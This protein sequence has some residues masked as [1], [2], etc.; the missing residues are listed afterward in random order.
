[1]LRIQTT[2]DNGY[3]DC[4]DGSDERMDPII[5]VTTPSQVMKTTPS[6]A[7]SH[8]KGT[9]LIT[10]SVEF[11]CANGNTV[12]VTKVCNDVDDCND[13]YRS[14]ECNCNDTFKCRKNGG[15]YW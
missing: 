13:G 6:P 8:M 4:G 15:K 11:T 14:D 10:S 2:V 3:D 1:M 5:N 7:T 12:D 9:D